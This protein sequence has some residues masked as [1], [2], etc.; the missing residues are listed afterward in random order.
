VQVEQDETRGRLPWD[1][2]EK[3]RLPAIRRRNGDAKA[4]ATASRPRRP[5]ETCRLGAG[6]DLPDASAGEGGSRT[7]RLGDAVVEHERERGAWSSH[8]HHPVMPTAPWL[9]AR[10]VQR[11]ITGLRMGGTGRQDTMQAER[12]RPRRAAT[13]ADREQRMGIGGSIFLIALG[14]ILRYGVTAEVSGL[15]LDAIGVIL[16]VVGIVG[17]VIS[18]VFWSG[19]G[20]W[21]PGRPEH[22]R[23]RTVERDE[24]VTRRY[25]Y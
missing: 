5:R 9:Q 19:L 10:A 3:R 4:A 6:D 8:H 24:E 23:A 16:V 18:I 20:T 21:Y 25:R 14:A 7:A 2:V 13:K 11:G 12:G 15:D 22:G 1:D 17:L